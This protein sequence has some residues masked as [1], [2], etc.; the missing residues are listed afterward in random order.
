MHDSFLPEL[1][2]CGDKDVQ[3]LQTLLTHYLQNGQYKQEPEGS[4]M[5]RVDISSRYDRE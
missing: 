5:P 4:N 1:A 2:E 3:P